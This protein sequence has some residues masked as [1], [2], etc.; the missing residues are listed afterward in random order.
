MQ[1]S[2]IKITKNFS[3]Q[4]LSDNKKAVANAITLVI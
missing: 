2:P 3:G 4:F 1:D